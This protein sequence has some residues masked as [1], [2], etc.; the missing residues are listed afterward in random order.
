MVDIEHPL[1]VGIRPEHA[2]TRL[3][4]G[5]V[6]EDVRAAEAVLN[7]RIERAQIFDAADVRLDRHDTVRAT[8]R[9]PGY[10]LCRA[11]EADLIHIRNADAKSKLRK[12]LRSGESN[13]GS[14]ARDNRDG[15]GSESRV[16]HQ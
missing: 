7:R 8:R 6:H 16:C 3:N 9:Q 15:S 11:I 10:L 13:A 5:I 2:A 4:P 14:A 1:P 12:A